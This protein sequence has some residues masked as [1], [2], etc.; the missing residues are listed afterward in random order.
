L[1]PGI[2]LQWQQKIADNL[3]EQLLLHFLQ[4]PQ[5]QQP[6]LKVDGGGGGLFPAFLFSPSAAE[7]KPEPDVNASL[8]GCSFLQS[9]TKRPTCF[10]LALFL[11]ALYRIRKQVVFLQMNKYKSRKN[12]KTKGKEKS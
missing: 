4:L 3:Q 7:Y 2:Q 8:A 1:L 5:L 10:F 11:R 12:F 9:L 6:L